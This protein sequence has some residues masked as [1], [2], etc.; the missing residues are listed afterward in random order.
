MIITSEFISAEYQVSLVRLAVTPVIE[1]LILIN[2][3]QPSSKY[4]K[5]F[6]NLN[7]CF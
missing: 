5:Y 4:L 1:T 2:G 3:F 7:Q 6:D